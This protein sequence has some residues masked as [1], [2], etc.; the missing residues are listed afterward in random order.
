MIMFN[1]TH[2]IPAIVFIFLGTTGC[3]EDD[4][5]RSPHG[6]RV[7]G[8]HRVTFDCLFLNESI[9]IFTFLFDTNQQITDILTKGSFSRVVWNELMTLC[10]LF[11]ESFHRSSSSVVAA[12]VPSARKMTK[13]SRHS[14]DQDSKVS[15]ASSE[16]NPEGNRALALAAVR[17]HK[18]SPPISAQEMTQSD[19]PRQQRPGR[20]SG[21]RSHQES[22]RQRNG[23]V[24]ME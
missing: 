19:V 16:P 15:V 8:T 9:R 7:S 14:R 17:H 5:G 6:R 20:A 21:D 13:R 2:Q 10:L 22:R 4:E 11:S 18:S 23:R 12:L 24:K 3:D 1:H